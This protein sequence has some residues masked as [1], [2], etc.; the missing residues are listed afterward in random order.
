[1]FDILRKAASK[2]VPK[3]V[4]FSSLVSHSLFAIES[5]KTLSISFCLISSSYFCLKQ[6][7]KVRKIDS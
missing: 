6:T 5:N 3:T 1:M 2:A 7:W 4:L